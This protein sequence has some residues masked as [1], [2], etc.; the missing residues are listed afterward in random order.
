[1][2]LRLVSSSFI[3]SLSET[4]K[5]GK[6]GQP[7]GVEA[8]EALAEFLDNRP[9]HVRLL[10]K[11]QYNRGVA[12]V[13]LK[14]PWLRRPMHVD[15]YM[16]KQGLAEVYRGGGAV[17]GPRGVDR[18]TVLEETAQTNRVGMWAQGSQR[19][20]AADYKKRTKS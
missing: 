11:D 4:A 13:F 7:F 5:F 3:L 9:V 20:S 14:S 1:M 2:F 10:Q 8:K 6:P 18:Y 19:E 16:L 17:Y 12:Q 15:E